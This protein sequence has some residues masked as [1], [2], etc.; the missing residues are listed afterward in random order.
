MK[1]GFLR[2]LCSKLPRKDGESGVA[3]TE[4]AL[5][6]PMLAILLTGSIDYS[7]VLGQYNRLDEAVRGG[8]R[9][10]T[11]TSLLE[12]GIYRGLAIRS[13]ASCPQL[14]ASRLHANLQDRIA[15]LVVTNNSRINADT[16]CIT[17]IVEQSAVDPTQ[18]IVRVEIGVTYDGVFP[19]LGA[20][21]LRTQAMGPVL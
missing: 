15:E 13:G 5:A 11:S 17:T 21:P 6:V 1:L 3:A 4:F 12:P 19:G 7:M 10:A 2:R 18:R 8:L 9:L 20:L 14:G 16:L